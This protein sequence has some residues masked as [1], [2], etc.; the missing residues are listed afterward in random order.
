[1]T[2]GDLTIALRQLREDVQAG[3]RASARAVDEVLK[4]GSEFR[5]HVKEEARELGRVRL[6]AETNKQRLDQ[7]QG[8]LEDVEETTGQIERAKLDSERAKAKRLE[9]RQTALLKWGMGIVAG[10]ILAACSSVA[11]YAAKAFVQDLAK[12]AQAGQR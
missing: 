3:T 5:M 8:G 2:E 7:L 11:G 4:L 12:P 10:L 9:D 6:L 1:M